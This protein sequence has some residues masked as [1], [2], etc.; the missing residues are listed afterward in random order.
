MTEWE[1]LRDVINN[2]SECMFNYRA[3]SQEAEIEITAERDRALAFVDKLETAMK[4]AGT[5]INKDYV[6]FKDMLDAIKAVQ[7]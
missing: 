7:P 4:L 3:L 1:H 6:E 5:W 2:G